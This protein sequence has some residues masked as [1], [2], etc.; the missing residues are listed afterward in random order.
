LQAGRRAQAWQRMRHPR[1]VHGAGRLGGTA[2]GSFHETGHA[3]NLEVSGYIGKLVL[4]ID[5]QRRSALEALP[6]QPPPATSP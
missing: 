1:S 2:V 5:V 6:S 3:L 4:G